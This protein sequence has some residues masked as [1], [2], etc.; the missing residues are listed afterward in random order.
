MVRL[1]TNVL[2]CFLLKDGRIL[3]KRIFPRDAAAVSSILEKTVDSVCSEEEDVLREYKSTGGDSVTVKNPSRFHGRQLGLK[4]IEDDAVVDI[5]SIA[6]DIGVSRKEVDSLVSDVNLILTREAMRDVEEEQDIMQAVG[7]IDDLEEVLNRMATRL[8]EWYSLHF[9]E[10]GNIVEEHEVYVRL[11][12]EVGL[13][14]SFS[15]SE[16]GLD[17][18]QHQRIVEC[19]T[20]SIG[21]GWG[22]EDYEPVKELSSRILSMYKTKAEIE[23]FIVRR[24]SKVAPNISALAGPLLGA[25]VITI[26]GGMKRLSIMPAG[27]IQILGAED[28]FFRFLKTGKKPPKHGVIFQLPEI[29]GAPQNQ[30][31]KIART[32]AA[33][34]ALASRSDAF[35]GDFIGDKLRSDFEARVKSLN[36]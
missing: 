9:P 18:S 22:E 12:N 17:G 24:M 28:A 6:E 26:A 5:Y 29:R 19:S 11:V 34:L 2:G 23:G 7:C 1:E 30:R 4:F 27:T 31:G 8:R 3:S 21:V 20:D 33:K 16:T 36:S 25:R 15:K 32:F 14:E 13:R 35:K 10:L